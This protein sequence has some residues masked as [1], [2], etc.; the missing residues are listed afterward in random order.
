MCGM[1][2]VGREA[3]KRDG[4]S[5]HM[6]LW[7]NVQSSRTRRRVLQVR[8]RGRDIAIRECARHAHNSEDESRDTCEDKPHGV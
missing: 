1:R 5:K 8:D 3:R 7:T 2:A 4:D 6:T